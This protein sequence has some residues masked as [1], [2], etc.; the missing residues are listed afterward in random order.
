MLQFA[1]LLVSSLFLAVLPAQAKTITLEYGRIVFDVPDGFQPLMDEISENELPSSRHPRYAVGSDNA[2][3]TIAYDIKDSN[4]TADKL[5][6]V[7]KAFAKTFTQT[8]PGIEWKENKLIELGGKEWIYFEFKSDQLDTDV[9]NIMLTTN[10]DGKMLVF[11]VNSTV[12][13]F[14]IHEPALRASIQSIRVRENALSETSSPGY[15]QAEGEV[16]DFSETLQSELKRVG[17][18]N[19]PIDGIWG[20]GSEAALADFGE[21]RGETFAELEPTRSNLE[22]VLEIRERVCPPERRPAPVVKYR[23]KVEPRKASRPARRAP[24]K[25]AKK[26]YTFCIDTG[27]KNKIVDCDDPTA[28]LKR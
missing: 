4:I 22:A 2:A 26:K 18:Y 27:R 25:K 19:G 28:D 6:N 9:N 16:E 5:D 7:R 13:D 12:A 1:I 10:F 20:E 14:E 21:H 17:C 3:T 23:K 24:K 8:V 15:G 11:N